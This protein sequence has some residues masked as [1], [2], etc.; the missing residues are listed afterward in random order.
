V[1]LMVINGHYRKTTTPQ[2]FEACFD[3][4][5]NLTSL[6]QGVTDSQIFLR[7]MYDTNHNFYTTGFFKNYVK[8]GNYT[9]QSKG[10]KIF[11]C[12]NIAEK[13]R[14]GF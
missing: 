9:L 10:W 4:D 12:I 2:K 5:F 1:N 13:L 8:F 6:H 3:R 7:T 11:L 14:Y